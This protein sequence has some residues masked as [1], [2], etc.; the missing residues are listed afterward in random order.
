MQWMG[1]RGLVPALRSLAHTAVS[2]HPLVVGLA[3]VW[4]LAA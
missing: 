4:K 1:D 3:A 2:V